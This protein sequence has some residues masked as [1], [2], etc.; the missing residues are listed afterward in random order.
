MNELLKL[1]VVVSCQ[2]YVIY[3]DKHVEDD[4]I[5]IVDEEACIRHRVGEA[6]LNEKRSEL[7]VPGTR[8]L[9]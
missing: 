3:I 8:G 6:E 9:F 4:P 5:T 7:V 2:D 1:G